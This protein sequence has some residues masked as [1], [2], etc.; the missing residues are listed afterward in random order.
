MTKA[1]I[2]GGLRRLGVEDGIAGEAEDVVG[3]VVLRPV[4]RLD[5]AVVSSPK[6]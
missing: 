3:V 2:V 6:K 4:H 1:Q 5:A